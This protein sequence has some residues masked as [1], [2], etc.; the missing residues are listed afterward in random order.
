MRRILKTIVAAAF[1]LLVGIPCASAQKADPPQHRF[2]MRV[3]TLGVFNL[4]L[5]GDIE[6][7]LS[8]RIGLFVGGGSEFI[9]PTFSADVANYSR[10]KRRLLPTQRI[11]VPMLA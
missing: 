7:S 6:Y 9:H 4:D 3:N 10:R 2:A 11:G 5:I 8:S 1:S